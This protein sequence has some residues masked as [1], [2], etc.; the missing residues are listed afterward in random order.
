MGAA[1]LSESKSVVV[2]GLVTSTRSSA[3]PGLGAPELARAD[4]VRG[5]ADMTSV[6]A[7]QRLSRYVLSLI[8]DLDR[9]VVNRHPGTIFE[10][11]AK[12]VSFFVDVFIDLIDQAAGSTV[13]LD[14]CLAVGDVCIYRAM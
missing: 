10:S 8:C 14:R 7:R 11:R 3:M 9:T 5:E 2:P 4:T 12:Q 13:Y 6:V 1:F